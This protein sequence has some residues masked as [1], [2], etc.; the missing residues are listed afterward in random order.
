MTPSAIVSRLAAVAPKAVRARR[1]TPAPVR[2]AVRLKNDPPFD[3]ERWRYGFLVDT[4]FTRDTW[5]HRLDISR[6]TAL[7][8]TG[9]AGGQWRSGEAGA[10]PARCAR[11]LLDRRRPAARHRAHGHE[12]PILISITRVRRSQVRRP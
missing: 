11:L 3:A 10:P 5:M 1:R 4:I 12:G 9:T 2:W 6:A 7:T 8:L